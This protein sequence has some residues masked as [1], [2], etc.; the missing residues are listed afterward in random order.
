MIISKSKYTETETVV[1]SSLVQQEAITECEAL[2][3]PPHTHTLLTFSKNA[4]NF[5][6]YIRLSER[7]DHT[8]TFKADSLGQLRTLI[9]KKF[10]STRT[11]DNNDLY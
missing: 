1:S 3:T 4:K 10:Y 8:R 6:K 2:I 11:A 7:S 9:N 5:T